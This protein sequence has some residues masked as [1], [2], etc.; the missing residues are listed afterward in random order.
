MIEKCDT[1]SK[2]IWLKQESQHYV[3]HF[4]KNSYASKLIDIVISEQ[5]QC[6]K[7]I[8]QLLRTIPVQ[9]IQYWLCD[10]AEEVGQK[11]NSPECNGITCC[12]DGMV[13]IYCVYSENIKC[14]GYHEDTHAV[15][16]FYNDIKSDAL[17]EGLA[18]YMDKR[19][20]S[21]ENE[22]CTFV[23]IENNM[24]VSVER[25]ICERNSNDE[26]YFLDIEDC[27]S[28]PI[29][30]AFVAFLVEQKGTDNFLR[31]YSYNGT[32]WK[33]EFFKI[34]GCSL[35]EVEKEFIDYIKSKK[36]TDNQKTDA[37]SKLCTEYL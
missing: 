19:W 31:L 32:N 8:S 13:N 21:V 26:E 36:Y 35:S 2:E 37:Y 11:S 17:A 34:Y 10:S 28:Y 12:E 7:D 5:E 14:T 20:W 25:M 23:Y 33:V 1:N 29:M 3:F 16:Y 15:A 27:Y 4:K 18:M 9:K 22:L 30:G 6:F 24:Y